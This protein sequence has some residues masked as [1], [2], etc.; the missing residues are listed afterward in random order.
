MPWQAAPVPCPLCPRPSCPLPLPG[1]GSMGFVSPPAQS[2]LWGPHFTSFVPVPGCPQG[3]EGTDCSMTEDRQT[4]PPRGW[5]GLGGGRPPRVSREQARSC[6]PPA[7]VSACVG[8]GPV[9]G[10]GVSSGESRG[11]GGAQPHG[12]GAHEPGKA[13]F[14]VSS[15]AREADAE[16]VWRMAFGVRCAPSALGS[17]PLHAPWTRFRG[18]VTDARV[19]GVCVVCKGGPQAAMPASLAGPGG[20][21][22]PSSARGPRGGGG[23]RRS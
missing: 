18:H 21:P 8:P 15:L 5:T 11:A 1:P 22:R 6:T 23:T 13:T 12:H 7:R 10:E 4:P 3:T 16:E 17:P 20:V 2:L 19:L 9:L 14:A